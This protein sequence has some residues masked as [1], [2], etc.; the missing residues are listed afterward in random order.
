MSRVILLGA[1]GHSRSLIPVIKSQ[2]LDIEGVYDDN[3]STQE[4]IYPGVYLKGKLS[5]KPELEEVISLGKIEERVKLLSS[6]NLLEDNLIS[7]TAFIEST[8]EL[9][10]A[11]QIMGHSFI[12]SMCRI[13]DFNIINTKAL[14]EHEC[15]IGNNNHIAIGA[16]LAGR[17]KIGSNC[18]IGAGSVIV[19]KV[20]ICSNVIIGAGS[21]VTKDITSPGTYFGIPA[22]G[23]S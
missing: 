6:E 8:A 7:S 13:G 2:G 18:F 14:I 19:D 22:R 20:S 5:Q 11:N 23:R 9:G 3:F 12:N 17:V 16:S 15:I 21:V 1:G 4:E 10:V